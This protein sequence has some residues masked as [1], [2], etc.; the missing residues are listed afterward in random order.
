VNKPFVGSAKDQNVQA[1]KKSLPAIVSRNFQ[2]ELGVGEATPE[3]L[4]EVLVEMRVEVRV[5]ADVDVEVGVGVGVGVGVDMD[6][7]VN[8]DT[9][10]DTD[11]DIDIDTDVNI[12]INVGVGVGVG[13]EV[14]VNVKVSI[15]GV[16]A[17]VE[18]ARV[19][20]RV[21]VELER[22]VVV[23]LPPGPGYPDGRRMHRLASLPLLR[24]WNARRGWRPVTS[25]KEICKSRIK[26][27][28]RL[29]ESAKEGNWAAARPASAR[30][31]MGFIL[32]DYC[33]ICGCR[34][35]LD[36]QAGKRKNNRIS[37]ARFYGGWLGWT[38]SV[39]PVFIPRRKEAK[40][41]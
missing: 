24:R 31:V 15:D 26:L 34:R 17:G 27:S 1:L 25:W 5:D 19:E 4:V 10:I 35:A 14:D 33:L 20:V 23:E 9:D 39:V 8:T 6:I 29:S 3:V 13:V 37:L 38:R 2:V 21:A 36:Q 16:A 40:L 7:D 28:T 32:I 41:K 11:V 22:V 30:A 12:D 18:D